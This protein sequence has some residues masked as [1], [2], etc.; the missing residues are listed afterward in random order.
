VDEESCKTATGKTISEWCE[1][2]DAFDGLKKGR[3]PCLLHINEVTKE[4]WWPTTISV[5]YERRK[6]AVKKDGLIEGFSI[7][8]T[9]TINAPVP[10]VY[11]IW[12]DPAGFA[13]FFGD[14]AKQDVAEGGTISCG[15]GCKGTFTRIR[16]DKDLRFTF[17]YPG[18]TAPMTVDVQFQDAKGKTLM[19]VMTSRIQTREEADGLRD[20]WAAALNKLKA[21][22]EA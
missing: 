14:G 15:A 1:D 19:N 16:P 3:R 13:E 10:K 4:Y 6:G 11:A 17:E 2:L 21:L 22:A 7:C 9:K 5:E 8:S 20:A 12:T 18:C